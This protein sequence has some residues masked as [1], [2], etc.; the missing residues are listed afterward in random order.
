MEAQLPNGRENLSQEKDHFIFK[1][2][3]YSGTL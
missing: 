3:L 1:D 2:S